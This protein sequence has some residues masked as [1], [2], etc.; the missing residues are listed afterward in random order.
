MYKNLYNRTGVPLTITISGDPKV[1][2]PNKNIRIT[3]QPGQ[4]M[5][6]NIDYHYIGLLQPHI[7]IPEVYFVQS[8][9][10]SDKNSDL[11]HLINN[12]DNLQFFFDKNQFLFSIGYY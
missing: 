4:I 12:R 7:N 2:P 11:F 8:Y 1:D 6:V 3:I 10:V 5:T 9:I